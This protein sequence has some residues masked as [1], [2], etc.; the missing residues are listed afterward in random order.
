MVDSLRFG[1]VSTLPV[2]PIM[3][4]STDHA[5]GVLAVPENQYGLVGFDF[6]RR[7]EMNELYVLFNIYVA[8]DKLDLYRFVFEP[9]RYYSGSK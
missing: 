5:T 9:M 6:H 2:K 4:F 8:K 7:E 1:P 3:A